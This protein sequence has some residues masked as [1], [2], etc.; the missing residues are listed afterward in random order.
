MGPPGPVMGLKKNSFPVI[1][2][3]QLKRQVKAVFLLH[4]T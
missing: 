4:K 2:Q 3:N 1:Q